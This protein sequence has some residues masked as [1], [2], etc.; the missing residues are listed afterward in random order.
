MRA[1]LGTLGYAILSSLVPI[2]NVEI[3]LVAIA[4]QIPPGLAIPV[5]VAAGVGQAL[6]KVVW[7]YGSLKS[8]ELPW[9]RKRMHTE[10]WKRSFDK[11]QGRVHD[12]P[13]AAGAFM[14]ISALVGVPPLL[15]MGAVA[16]ALRMN[17]VMFMTTIIVGRSIQS[18]VILAGLTHLFH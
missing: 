16:G 3:Y 2:F 14:F 12:R 4:T 7:Y 18:W 6:G 17:M 13:W 9:M 8:M 1:T 15:V 10:R 11:W 5:A